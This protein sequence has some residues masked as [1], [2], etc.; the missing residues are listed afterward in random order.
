MADTSLTVRPLGSAIVLGLTGRVTLKDLPALRGEVEKCL[1]QTGGHTFVFDCSAVRSVD[2]TFLGF[3]VSLFKTLR[4]AGRGLVLANLPA[5]AREA[6]RVT[7][8]TQIFTIHD[9]LDQAL[10]SLKG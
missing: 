9:T 2:S 5:E 8:L 6:L 7:G 1:S 10:Q 3:L 4:G